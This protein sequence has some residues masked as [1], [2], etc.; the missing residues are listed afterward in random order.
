MHK[1]SIRCQKTALVLNLVFYV[2]A[3]SIQFSSVTACLHLQWRHQEESCGSQSEPCL[4]ISPSPACWQDCLSCQ[5]AERD[6]LHARW[7]HHHHHHQLIPNL[8]HQLNHG[9]DWRM[10]GAP[11]LTPGFLFI[12]P[13]VILVLAHVHEHQLWFIH[14]LTAELSSQIQ[15]CHDVLIRL[16][17]MIHFSDGTPTSPLLHWTS[18]SR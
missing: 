14:K 17:T 10:R 9:C 2:K 11:S 1:S 13:N 6:A 5:Q 4:L 15:H 3:Q 8:Q 18:H 7:H 16:V 12:S